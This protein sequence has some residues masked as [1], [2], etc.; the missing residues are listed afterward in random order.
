MR[1][2]DGSE[3]LGV[4]DPRSATI[5]VIHVAP[6]DDRPSVLT[7]ILLQEK[8]GRDQVVIVLPEQNKA[9]Q[10][11]VA[12]DGL[13]NMRRGL[14]AQIIFVAPSGPG[15]AEFARQR[16][17]P[18][19]SSLEDYAETFQ[20]ESSTQEDVKRGWLFGRREKSQ[21]ADP[22]TPAPLPI[23][24][25]EDE[26][27]QPL[28]G[29][30]T[31]IPEQVPVEANG[32][33]G[34]QKDQL[35]SPG[36]INEEEEQEFPVAAPITQEDDLVPVEAGGEPQP[37]AISEPDSDPDSGVI[38]FHQPSS[39]P[40]NS[41][42]SPVVPASIVP[43]HP[44]R[45]GSL[46][47][48]RSGNRRPWLIAAAVLLLLLIGGYIVS[49]VFFTTPLSAT[50][51][52]TPVSNDLKNTYT[53]SAV[54][55]TPDLARRQV[56]ARLLFSTTPMQSKTVNATGTGSIAATQ[57]VG[58]LTFYNSANFMQSIPVN[59]VFVGADG[60]VVVNDER[61]DIPAANPPLE[62]LV[63]VTA[64]AVKPG[65]SGDISAFDING[66]CCL[67]GVTVRNGAAFSGGQDAQSYTYVQQSDIDGAA[68]TLES[69]LTENAQASLQKQMHANEQLAGSPQCLSNVTANHAASDKV[70]NVTVNVAVTCL[71]EVYNHQDAVLMT[72]G[73]LKVEAG[74]KLGAGYSLVGNVVS[75]VTQATV[76]KNDTVLLLVNAE[77]LWVYQFSDAQ[78]KSLA[79]LIAGR[80]QKDAKSLLQGQTGV[81][82]ATIQLSQSG[83]DTLPMDPRQITIV[84]QSVAG[85]Q[86]TPNN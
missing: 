71:G 37:D 83:G 24:T 56:Q 74:N 7:A 67:S 35:L 1:Q 72:E 3:L 5:G 69:S 42:P 61:A 79:K 64:H 81:S 76:G 50:V 59:T 32:E 54:I 52:I 29:D 48:A 84:T 20:G 44:V 13:K 9:F 45:R 55:G 73:L 40:V 11:P 86:G 18:V 41:F 46:P 34:D 4:N 66:P 58:I 6:N 68:N 39:E 63:T 78:K 17:F 30:I 36:A 49:R 57:A 33:V 60:V 43:A 26:Q 10:R 65:A 51:T 2:D 15:P 77:G 22:D 27:T 47:Y 53:I 21:R 19:Y 14:Q 28:P 23:D 85:I 62:G 70:A 8:L 75:G 80:S 16:R 31:P 25:T 38:T 82:K 12:F